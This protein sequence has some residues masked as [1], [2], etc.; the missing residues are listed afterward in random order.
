MQNKTSIL[1]TR[2]IDENL[3]IDAREADID[4]DQ[5][6]FIET[7]A[8]ET[9]LLEQQINHSFSQAITIIF[10]SMNAV[11][12]VADRLN[13]QQPNWKIYCIGTTTNKL[14]AQ[15]FGQQNIVGTADDATQLAQ[16]IVTNNNTD[17]VIFFCGDQRRDELPNIL[18]T[19]NIEV[20][21]MVVYH[22]ISIPLKIEKKYDGI[23]FFS[24][25]AAESFFTNNKIPKSTILFAIGNTTSNEIKKYTNNAII[26]ADKP[27]KEQLVTKMIAHYKAN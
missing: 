22:T 6:T 14:V 21:E 23:L 18:K 25:S 24:P 26:V 27:G 3:I 9:P 16:L 17:K 4:I 11:E 19:N 5:I 20:K 7:V 10:T 2:P 8:L 15:Y 12:A 13:N 1:C